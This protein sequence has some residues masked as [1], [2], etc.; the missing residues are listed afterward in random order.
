MKQAGAAGAL[1]GFCGRGVVTA[2]VSPVSGAGVLPP[3]SP[4]RFTVFAS[5]FSL[6]CCHSTSLSSESRASTEGTPEACLAS[7]NGSTVP[8]DG[9]R[10][11]S[12]RLARLCGCVG[13]RALGT[14]ARQDLRNQ[15]GV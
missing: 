4:C 9:K 15:A 6:V 7:W 14:M 8:D 1:A 10:N 2:T 13:A 3:W 11:G 12:R 5:L